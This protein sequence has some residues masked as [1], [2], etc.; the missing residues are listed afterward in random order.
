LFF[1]KKI[2]LVQKSSLKDKKLLLQSGGALP[3]ILPLVISSLASIVG[4]YLATK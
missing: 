3:A 4:S 2:K 1:L